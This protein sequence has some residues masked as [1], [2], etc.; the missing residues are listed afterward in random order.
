MLVVDDQQL[1]RRG[2]TMLLAV[3]P[4]LEVVGEAGD[5]VEGTALADRLLEGDL[6]ANLVAYGKGLAAAERFEVRFGQ[7]EGSN[8]YRGVLDDDVLRGGGVFVATYGKLPA[9][10]S[11]VRLRLHFPSGA[12]FE[13]DATV[14][15]TQDLVTGN[16]GALQPGFGARLL[17]LPSE[18]R[19]LVTHYTR[20]VEPLLRE[21]T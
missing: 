8:F 2:L 20:R 11:T 4:G 19:A 13:A 5:G 1:F 6:D 21:A 16:A 18:A 15:F 9:L 14:T 7:G 3:E 10:G 12:S 17:E